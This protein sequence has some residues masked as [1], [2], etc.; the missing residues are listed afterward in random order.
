MSR[1]AEA[2]DR[3]LDLRRLASYS[4]LGVRRLRDYIAAAT[5]PLPAYRVGG[6]LL[7]RRSEFDRWMARRRYATATVDGIVDEVLHE[8]AGRPA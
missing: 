4:S 6:K 8:L 7:V 2:D 3:F 1:D 5:D